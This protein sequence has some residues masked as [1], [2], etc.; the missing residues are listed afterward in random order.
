MAA[1][2]DN[3][4][5]GRYKKNIIAE[6][7]LEL[8]KMKVFDSSEHAVKEGNSKS[9]QAFVQL[10]SLKL[11]ARLTHKKGV[12]GSR[13]GPQHMHTSWVHNVGMLI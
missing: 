11:K 9:A 5:L 10:T 6:I 3:E 4:E 12:G 1:E 8:G 7:R 2:D 13:I